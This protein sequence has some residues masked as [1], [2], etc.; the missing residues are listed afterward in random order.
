MKHSCLSIILVILLAILAACASTQPY[1]TKKAVTSI[2]F[3][4]DQLLLA[5]ANANEIRVLEVG[6][7]RLV[8]TLR[9]LPLDPE[10]ADPQLFRHGVGDNMVFLDNNRIATSGMGGLVT[11]WNVHSGRRL[12]IIDPLPGEEFASTIDYSP[13]A[14]RLVIGTSAGQVLLTTLKNDN[15]GPLLPSHRTAKRLSVQPGVPLTM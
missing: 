7:Q 15:A 10:G 4:P 11:I 5:F 9:D 12:T 14:N 6:S 2:A 13:V 1:Q 3:S 8:N